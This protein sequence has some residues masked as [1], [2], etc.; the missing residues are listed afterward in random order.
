[1]HQGWDS[2]DAF[3]PRHQIANKREK[4]V[5]IRRGPAHADSASMIHCKGQEQ[6]TGKNIYCKI[7]TLSF[8]R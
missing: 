1:M 8:A 3:C 6:T 7:A 4:L 2:R 5:I